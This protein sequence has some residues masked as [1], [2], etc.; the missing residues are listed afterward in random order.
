MFNDIF[1]DTYQSATLFF[2]YVFREHDWFQKELPTYLFPSPNDQDASIVDMAVIGDVCE[3]RLIWP[4]PPYP[5]PM[6]PPHLLERTTNILIS[7]SQ[8]PGCL[9]CG[10]GSHRRCLW[11]KAN[12]ITP[13]TPSPTPTST[14]TPRK[15]YRYTCFFLWRNM[16]LLL[17]TVDGFI[18]VGTN[19]RGFKKNQTFVGFKIHGHSIIFHN[20]YRNLL[21]RWDPPRKPRKLVP[22]WKLSHPQYIEVIRLSVR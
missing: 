7:F 3:V 17:C 9:Y 13:S 2:L 10:Y 6:P 21:F 12:Y 4:T 11:G 5:T 1:T 22:P 18:F 15:N 20:S 14:P 8:W 19:F 16:M